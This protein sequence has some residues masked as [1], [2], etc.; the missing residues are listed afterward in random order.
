MHALEM[1]DPETEDLVAKAKIKVVPKKGTSSLKYICGATIALL[2]L[3]FFFLSWSKHEY[4][5]QGDTMQKMLD[6]DTTTSMSGSLEATPE[7]KPT[8]IATPTETY[9]EPEPTTDV[10]PVVEPEPKPEPEEAAPDEASTGEGFVYSKRATIVPDSD[11]EPPSDEEKKALTEKWGRW[12]FWD[13]DAEHRPSHDYIAKYPFGDIPLDEIP[14][15]AWQ[16]DAVY[17]NHLID[18]AQNLLTRAMEAIF[19]E[20]GHGKP[21]PPEGLA[22]RLKMFKWDNIQITPQTT[23][24]DLPLIWQPKK[25]KSGG[26]WTTKRSFNGLVKRILH[27][28]MTN[29]DFVVVMGGHSAAAGHGNHFHQSYMMQFHRI[30]APVFARL[31]VRLVTRNMA[32]GGL[33]TLH[34][35]MG[36][37]SLYGDDIDLLIWDSGMTENVP[38]HIELFFRQA[39][40]QP[41]VPVIWNAPFDIAKLLYLEADADV[42]EVGRGTLGVP[43]TESIEEANSYPWAARYM[44]CSKDTASE[45]QAK[46]YC[47]K[48]WVDRP[49]INVKDMFPLYNPKPGG[50]VRWHPGWRYHQLQGRVIA[51]SILEALQEAMQIFSEGTMGG[52][53]LDQDYWHIGEYYANIRKKAQALD[54]SKGVCEANKEFFPARICNIV[55]RVSDTLYYMIQ[56]NLYCPPPRDRLLYSVSRAVHPCIALFIVLTFYILYLHR[57]QHNTHLVATHH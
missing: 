14:D 8:A 34:S 46:A 54:L 10:E 47:V 12:H 9:T 3:S 27:A 21:L 50:Q 32:Q 38:A 6:L 49:D 31:G 17:V 1:E 40:M 43:H 18:D 19:S 39:L 45:C 37:A 35:S 20:Y 4:D 22:E 28:I 55:M 23:T 2:A 52:P 26:G 5:P 25:A 7:E 30:C 11:R 53:P 48:C 36:F 16:A 13:G 41:K 56:L 29:G 57:A 15:N 33:G 44:E 51:F 42:G 24:H